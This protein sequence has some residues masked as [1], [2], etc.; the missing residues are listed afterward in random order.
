MPSLLVGQER[1]VT[2]IVI[3]SFTKKT[4]ENVKVFE[5]KFGNS[6][7][8]DSSGFFRIEFP[9]KSR[10]L[11]FSNPEYFKLS[12]PCPP[13]VHRRNSRTILLKPLNFAEID[14]IWKSYKNA[15]TLSI[16][17]FIT[18]AVAI[19][20]ER[21]LGKKQSIGLHTSVYLW[22]YNNFLFDLGSN[23]ASY[24][25]I[26]LAPFYRYYP[27]KS[28]SGGPYLEAKIPFG[29]FDFD[30]LV[31]GYEYDAYTKNFPQK[32]S[33][34]GGAVAVGYMFRYAKGNHGVGN[35]SVGAQFFPMIVPTKEEGELWDGTVTYSLNNAWWYITGPG[36]ILEIKFTLGGLF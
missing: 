17:E 20:Y 34:V 19:R 18:G 8:T 30:Q 11:L 7:I 24:Q 5:P 15:L 13:G 14:T 36:S 16:N 12:Y 2:G 32:F 21:F 3:N 6:A 22:G 29:Y 10:K 9:K 35:I 4:V 31:Y 23:P 25:G 28:N 26:K 27:I 1:F 33:T